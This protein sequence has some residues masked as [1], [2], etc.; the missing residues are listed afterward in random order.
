[1]SAEELGGAIRARNVDPEH[2]TL[3]EDHLKQDADCISPS[4]AYQWEQTPH[5]GPVARRIQAWRQASLRALCR[6]W[7]PRCSHGGCCTSKGT[8]TAEDRTEE[9]ELLHGNTGVDEH[10][11]KHWRPRE[12]STGSSAGP[13]ATAVANDAIEARL[14]SSKKRSIALD[15]GSRSSASLSKAGQGGHTNTTASS[16]TAP[17]ETRPNEQERAKVLRQCVRDRA[18]PVRSVPFPGCPHCPP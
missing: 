6:A 12:E 7:C 18:A 2:V 16:K 4:L 17:H 14:Q 3:A 10:G 11:A 13:A 15:Y 1:M 8:R 9:E 5:A